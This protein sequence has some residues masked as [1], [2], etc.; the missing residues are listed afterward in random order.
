[1]QWF[2]GPSNP[3]TDPVR[4]VP[5]QIFTIA[6][7]TERMPQAITLADLDGDGQLELVVS[8]Q[9]ALLWFEPDP[10]AT[11]FDQWNE[12]LIVD[13]SPPEQ[14][15]PAVTDPNVDPDA[16]DT[17][18]TLINSVLG[19]DL[20]NDGLTDIIATLDRQGQSGL[21]ND[22]LIWYRNNGP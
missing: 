17:P 9:G 1:M 10:D 7:F 16:I 20:Q 18:T 15:T 11:V 14:T 6:E 3:T 12:F 13:D 8:A 22:A 19:V 5:W 21:T 2:R 4:N